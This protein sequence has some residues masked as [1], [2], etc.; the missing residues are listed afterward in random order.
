MT[1]VFA[2][3]T[4]LYFLPTDEAFYDVAGQHD[5]PGPNWFIPL[6]IYIS[7]AM[8]YLV[9][10]LFMGLAYG[11]GEGDIRE[12]YPGKL[13]SLDALV[14]GRLFSQ[15]VMSRVSDRMRAGRLDVIAQQSGFTYP[16][17]ANRVMAKTSRR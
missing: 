7:I 11:S 14:T 6:I 15:N 17:K 9:M 1:V 3:V 2:A 10:G 8:T 16:G 12:S 5:F 13:T 4:A